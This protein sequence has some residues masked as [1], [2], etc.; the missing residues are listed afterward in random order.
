MH[1]YF[2]EV[3]AAREL[4]ASGKTG[5]VLSARMRNATPGP[6]WGDWFFSRAKV[7]SGVV[8]QLGV[9]GIDLLRHFFGEIDTCRN[10]GPAPYRT[11][12][13]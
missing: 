8:L 9:H 2:E 6:D 3:V 10:D 1:R 13:A 4:I 5:K 12:F 7:G 11:H